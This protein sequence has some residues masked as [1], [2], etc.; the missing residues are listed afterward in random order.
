MFRNVSLLTNT[1]KNSRI[2]YRVASIISKWEL[3]DE[4]FAFFAEFGV[5]PLGIL[6][7]LAQYYMMAW[8]LYTQS[9]QVSPLAGAESPSQQILPHLSKINLGAE[10]LLAAV[11]FS[12]FQLSEMLFHDFRKQID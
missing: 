11:S 5:H 9:A 12:K 4:R 3:S 6:R 1:G 2:L 8:V 10:R 7:E